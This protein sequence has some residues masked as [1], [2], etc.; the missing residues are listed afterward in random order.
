QKYVVSSVDGTF[1]VENVSEAS[2]NS[3]PWHVS[4]QSHDTHYCSGVLVQPR[5]V[6]APRHCC[7]FLFYFIP[8]HL[9][10]FFPHLFSK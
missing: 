1:K 8:I 9:F 7:G 6:L 2:A 3:W 10:Y 5:W 4:L